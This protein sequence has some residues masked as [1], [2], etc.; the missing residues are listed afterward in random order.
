MLRS[1]LSDTYVAPGIGFTPLTATPNPDFTNEEIRDRI[2]AQVAKC[3]ST[4]FCNSYSYARLGKNMKDIKCS[5]FELLNIYRA[6]NGRLEPDGYDG[7]PTCCVSREQLIS[8]YCYV[9]S[10]CNCKG[11]LS[12]AYPEFPAVDERCGCD[13]GIT[14][15][16]P[17]DWDGDD[18]LYAGIYFASVASVDGHCAFSVTIQESELVISYNDAE[19]RWELNEGATNMG[20]SSSLYS[21]EWQVKLDAGAELVTGSVVCGNTVPGMCIAVITDDGIRQSNA[22]PTFLAPDFT[23]PVGYTVFGEATNLNFTTSPYNGWIFSGLDANGDPC[24]GEQD[25]LG[26]TLT[27]FPYGSHVDFC[28]RKV[29][30]QSGPCTE[31]SPCNSLYAA[32]TPKLNAENGTHEIALAASGGTAPYTAEWF[33]DAGHTTSIATGM[34]F[35]AAYCGTTYYFVV[36]DANG[37]EF[38]WSH[39]LLCPP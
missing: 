13:D 1:I 2:N 10:Y 36:T 11:M 7:E 14:L 38:A 33:S 15:M 23:N 18:V 27:S 5:V 24:E 28:D 29:V 20:Y 19:S 30:F 37:C 4:F 34:G 12:E 25:K 22:H 39:T 9:Y 8:I 35:N 3:L 21:N 6:I 32:A 17:Y 26:G 16:F 31:L